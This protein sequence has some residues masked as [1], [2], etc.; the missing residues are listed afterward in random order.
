[1]GDYNADTVVNKIQ[2]GLITGYYAFIPNT[3]LKFDQWTIDSTNRVINFADG[4]KRY[5]CKMKINPE[6][7]PIQGIDE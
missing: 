6:A 3:P 7:L 4:T 1:M 5:Q 2:A